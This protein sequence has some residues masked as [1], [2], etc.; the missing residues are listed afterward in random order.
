MYVWRALVETS[1][2]VSFV[3]VVAIG[4]QERP[5][6]QENT[7]ENCQAAMPEIMKQYNNARYAVETA[8][9]S[10]DRGHILTAVNQAQAALDT[11]E[12]PLKVCSEAVQNLKA[13]QPGGKNS[14]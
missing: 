11:M 9:N 13:N 7:L 4:Q 2:V 8:R 12:Q 6:Q 10:G 5:P 3:V 14:N 1:V